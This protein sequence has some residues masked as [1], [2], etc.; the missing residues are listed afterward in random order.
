MQYKQLFEFDFKAEMGD[1]TTMKQLL[2]FTET[3]EKLDD[4]ETAR[5]KE[6]DLQTPTELANSLLEKI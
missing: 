4:V 3:D 2:E 1:E 6:K 5:L